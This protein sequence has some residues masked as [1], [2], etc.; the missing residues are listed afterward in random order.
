VSFR[1]LIEIGSLIDIRVLGEKVT[2]NEIDELIREADVDGDGQLNCDGECYN[3]TFVLI[4]FLSDQCILRR[5]H[6]SK[7][8]QSHTL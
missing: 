3:S 4:T 5:V 6:Q 7:N 1:A 2:D 8:A